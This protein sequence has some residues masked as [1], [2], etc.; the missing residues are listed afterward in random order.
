M[1]MPEFDDDD[2]DDAQLKA[3]AEGV[4]FDRWLNFLNAMEGLYS[5]DFDQVRERV[6]AE[7]PD[8]FKFDYGVLLNLAVARAPL[9]NQFLYNPDI[10]ATD[11]QRMIAQELFDRKPYLLNDVIKMGLWN[12]LHEM[13][14]NAAYNLATQ[15]V[16]THGLDAQALRS[17]ELGKCVAFA[18]K[19]NLFP[20]LVA[21]ELNAAEA[22]DYGETARVVGELFEYAEGICKDALDQEAVV[23]EQYLEGKYHDS[24]VAADWERRPAK[25]Q[26]EIFIRDLMQGTLAYFQEE[27]GMLQKAFHTHDNKASKLTPEEFVGYV[28]KRMILDDMHAE[29]RSDLQPYWPYHGD[30]DT[31]MAA[32]ALCYGA[33]FEQ[34]KL[35][36]RLRGFCERVFDQVYR[37]ASQSSK[38]GEVEYDAMFAKTAEALRDAMGKERISEDQ[39]LAS[40]KIIY[41]E[42]AEMMQAMRGNGKL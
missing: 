12:H 16:E 36:V 27:W 14:F 31:S 26:R 24:P 13:I 17:R 6:S 25:L 5:G 18:Q 1:G 28:N 35:L 41:A 19:H 29:E 22:T 21:E 8:E 2:D 32:E 23:W 4:R 40:V 38:G 33:R 42:A 15:Q 11:S 10:E 9:S 30:E 39:A 3:I 20:D 34:A 37:H 7:T